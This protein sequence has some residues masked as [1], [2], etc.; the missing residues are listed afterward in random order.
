MRIVYEGFDIADLG[1]KVRHR[2]YRTKLVTCNKI[3]RIYREV[4]SK[5]R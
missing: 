2:R 3:V 5:W 4:V 1:H